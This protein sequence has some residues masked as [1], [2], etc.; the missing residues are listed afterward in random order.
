MLKWHL[1]YEF[2]LFCLLNSDA[3]VDFSMLWHAQ[4]LTFK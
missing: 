2:G 1:V 3:F 4:M